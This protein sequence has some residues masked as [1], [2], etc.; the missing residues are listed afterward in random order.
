[1]KRYNK[2][3]VPTPVLPEIRT[4]EDYR[5]IYR[6]AGKWLPAVHEICRR[7][8]LGKVQLELAPPGTHVVFKVNGN[9]YVKLFA[10]FWHKDSLSERLTLNKLVRYDSLPISHKIADG[11]IEGW[12]Y[13]IIEAVEGIPLNKVWEQLDLLDLEGIVANCGEFMASLHSV[14][15]E[16]LNEIAVNWQEFVENQIQNCINYTVNSGLDERFI[17]SLCEF[18]EN[19]SLFL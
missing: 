16:G 15:T 1:M 18:A 5:Q 8:G 2:I 7:H 3:K 12:Q 10:P 9:K 6:D 19:Y 4:I 11:E 13:I 17:G 14:D